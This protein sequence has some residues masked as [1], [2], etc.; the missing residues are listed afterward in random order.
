[1]QTTVKLRFSTRVILAMAVGAGLIAGLIFLFSDSMTDDEYRQQCRDLREKEDW[2]ELRETAKAWAAVS[3]MPDEALLFQADAEYQSG[4]PLFA[5]DCLLS[6]PAKSSRCY[7]A[8]ITACDLQF[9]EVNRP[10][11]GVETLKKM[12]KRNPSSISSRQRLIFFYALTMQREKMLNAIYEAI[13]ARAEPPDCYTYLMIADRLT[14]SNGFEK[15]S[16]WLKSEPDSELFQVARTVQLLSVLKTGES[17]QN[18][19][20]L[21]RCRE[22]FKRL[23]ERYPQN[24]TLVE[25][26]ISEAAAEFDLAAVA[27]LIKVAPHPKTCVVLRWEGWLNFQNDEFMDSME[28]LQKSLEVFP[29]DWQTWNELSICKRRLGD[30]EGAE[31]AAQIA[32]VGKAIRKDVLQLEDTSAIGVKTLETMASYFASCGM[33]DISLAILVR[34]RA[35]QVPN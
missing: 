8:M 2:S 32:I 24:S 18:S 14:F 22:S 7:P 29:L 31:K 19:Q 16:E 21:V 34:L 28:A 13:Q 5:I 10:L 4:N 11:D 3:K 35:G 20:A 25:Q 15:N 1:M 17:T 23:M 6:V 26:A 12:I 27:A 30:L 33:N 9:G